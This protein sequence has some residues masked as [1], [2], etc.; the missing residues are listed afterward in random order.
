MPDKITFFRLLLWLLPVF[1]LGFS[2]PGAAA[3]EPDQ[4][5]VITP[6]RKAVGLVEHMRVYED[7]SADAG[8]RQI[9]DLPDSAWR[10]VSGD[11]FSGGYSSS[12][13]WL[14][15][16]LQGGSNLQENSPYILE[17]DIAYLGYVDF[18]VV[19]NGME[20]HYQTGLARPYSQRPEPSEII[21]LPLELSPG[22][23]INLHLRVES[24]GSLFVPAT[25]WQRTA[26]YQ[27]RLKKTLLFGGFF[28]LCLV[29]G[30]YNLFL[31][32]STRD[33]SY[34]F[35]T[36]NNVAVFWFQASA[37]GFTVHY[38][39]QDHFPKFAY[40]E[41][42]LSLWLGFSTILLFANSFLK[43]NRYHPRFNS[44]F[45]GLIIVCTFMGL[46]TVVSR[47]HRWIWTI[48]NALSPIVLL[49]ILSAGI[50]SMRKG[51]HAAR[52]FLL[53]WSF[54]L[55]SALIATFY[56]QGLLP[57][58]TFTK[59][60]S[61]YGSAIEGILLSIALADRINWIQ[62]EKIKAQLEVVEALS[63]TNRIKDEFLLTISHE[64]RTP[65]N[66][67]LGAAT[68]NRNE[69]DYGKL[70]ENNEL[71]MLSA[72]R[73]AESIEDLLCLSELNAGAMQV[74]SYPFQFSEK[75]HDLIETVSSECQKKGLAF[76]A[77]IN[78]V[79][80][81]HY[82][83]DHEKIRNVLRQLL[84]NAIAYTTDG[85]ISLTIK[86]VHTSN[87]QD[88]LSFIIKDTGT[89]IAPAKLDLIFDAFQQASGG[90]SRDNE[91]LGIGLSICKRLVEMMGGNIRVES[92][93]DQG[94]LFEV[95]LPLNRH[96]PAP[97]EP[98]PDPGQKNLTPHV[99]IVEDNLVNRQILR[100][101]LE[102]LH[103]RVSIATDG[104][105]AI[106]QVEAEKPDLILMD[107]QMPVM[108][109]FQSTEQIRAR[110][111]ETEL[112][113]VAVSANAMTKDKLRCFSV[114]M[115]DFLKKPVSLH[116][117]ESVVLRWAPKTKKARSDRAC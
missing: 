10:P 88:T 60:C 25:L 84:R 28:S 40:I 79:E 112:P 26:Y 58:N 37:H 21:L 31:Y 68:L 47:D 24:E 56:Y 99:L 71:I 38:L 69:K 70:E 13:F 82:L 36:L 61:L 51:N 42:H 39:W 87:V 34:L 30:I 101:M 89:G 81:R 77:D 103:C 86:A 74:D 20:T 67:I 100:K 32:F 7:T 15:L 91:G 19:K 117:L 83:G 44:L 73:M 93:T 27:N 23:E 107:C 29:L 46:M 9:R 6:A 102:K 64:L 3:V 11:V 53:G 111:S 22:D 59:Y 43:L 50:Y 104:Q 8:I 113:V 33:R 106:D 2:L 45:I 108:D 114:G 18:Y 1:A 66:G 63:Q 116:D 54:F 109:G 14:T 62:K 115:N 5:V 110:Y 49:T 41:P 98:D 92:A 52:F 80:N 90:Y 94:A 95:T 12:A 16:Q 35:Y 96:H 85:S 48:F 55:I 17:L 97:A 4:P 105:E 76:T 75:L 57:D 65:L 72:N 78:A